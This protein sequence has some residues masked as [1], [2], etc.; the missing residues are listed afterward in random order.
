[1]LTL[2]AAGTCTIA[3]NQSGDAFYNAAPQATLDIPVAASGSP[4]VTFTVTNTNNSG[5]GSLR[6]A[7]ANANATAPGPNIVNFTPA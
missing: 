2:L 4:P 7:I 3:A 1:M 5:V 6:T